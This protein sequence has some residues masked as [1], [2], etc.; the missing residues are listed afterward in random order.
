MGTQGRFGV[1]DKGFGRIA[2]HLEDGDWQRGK[3][4]TGALLPSRRIPL[5]LVLFDEDEVRHRLD[6]YQTDLR[7][8]G[9]VLAERDLAGRHLLGQSRVFLLAKTNQE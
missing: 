2:G 5:W 7:M 6:G 8:K 4:G 9:L 3:L 1:C